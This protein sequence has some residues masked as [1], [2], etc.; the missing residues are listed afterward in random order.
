MTLE[1]IL[2]RLI[3]KKNNFVSENLVVDWISFKF[4]QLDQVSK[5]KI[6]EFLFQ[7]E[8]NS[9]QELGTSMN[10][11]KTPILTDLRK[12]NYT[13]L[14]VHGSPYWSGTILVFSGLNAKYFYTLIKNKKVLWELFEGSI[15]NRFDL[16][17]SEKFSTLP[18]S[19]TEFFYTSKSHL[20]LKTSF[21]SAPF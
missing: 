21:S 3:M 13:A 18:E 4:Q 17:Y 8:F 15:I 6:V 7:H 12:H 1:R 20:K 16:Y 2:Y 10:P 19:I 5:D 9:Y 11:V 14:F